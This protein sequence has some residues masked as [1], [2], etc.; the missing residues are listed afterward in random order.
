MQTSLIRSISVN[1]TTKNLKKIRDFVQSFFEKLDLNGLDVN[2]IVLA[3][4]E[5]CSNKIIHASNQNEDEQ[6]VLNIKLEKTSTGITFEIIDF[7]LHFDYPEYQEPALTE[8]IESKAKGSLGMILV[9]KIMDS[10]EFESTQ[11]QNICRLFKKI[12]TSQA[13]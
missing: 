2:L 12:P 11:E 10:I 8:L 4:D 1:C 13:A 7:G 3:I 6:I 5:I 9:R